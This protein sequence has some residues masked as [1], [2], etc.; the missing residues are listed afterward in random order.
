[1]DADWSGAIARA[2]AEA[3]FL[4]RALGRLP[5]LAELLERGEGEAALAWARGAGGASDDP[6]RAL[7][8]ERL[9]IAA[10]LAIG[11]LAGAFPL[12]RIMGELSALADRAL[13]TAITAAIRARAGD[14]E[15]GGF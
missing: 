6:A 5:E 3:P 14:V 10:A 1:M 8:S 13:D 4:L 11:D 15:P 9:A 2:Q 12:D 7:R